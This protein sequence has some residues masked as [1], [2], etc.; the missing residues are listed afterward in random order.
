MLLA[1]HIIAGGLALVSGYTA[2][3]VAKGA[4]THRRSGMVFVV[5]MLVMVATGGGIAAWHGNEG[6][7]IGAVMTF[8]FVLTALVTVRR[9]AGWTRQ[10]DIG[11]TVLA[12]AGTALSFTLAFAALASPTKLWEGLPPFP[13]FMFGT[14]GT[15]A[16]VGDVRMLRSGLPRGAPRLARHLWRMCWAMWIAAGSFFFGQAKVIP[17]PI[18]KPALLAVPVLAVF[19]VMFYWLWRV[20]VKRSLRGMVIGR[21]AV[22]ADPAVSVRS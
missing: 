3:F 14:I 10:L 21:A 4:T 7:T 12:L 17:E 16:I 6:S 13:F 18:R 11:L 20:R 1:I 15:V 9:P 5:A 19:A 22:L 2:M 8:Y